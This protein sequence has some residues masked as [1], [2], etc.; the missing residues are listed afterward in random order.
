[1]LYTAAV[2]LGLLAGANALTIGAAGVR[3]TPGLK[4]KLERKP[5]EGDPFCDGIRKPVEGP[6]PD[7]GQARFVADAGYI[8]DDDEPWHST[9]RPKTAVIT[10]GML[11]S[12]F[13]SALPFIAP[14]EALMDTL[15]QVE[16]KG[17]IEAAIKKCLADGGRPGCPAIDAAEKSIKL[18]EKEGKIKKA[19]PAK[20]GAQGKG[21]DDMARSLAKTHD[22]SV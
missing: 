21:W 1:M 19:P 16:T 2:V 15:R 12:T 13:V 20:G 10:K 11:D 7:Q 17:E 18:G 22:N 9:C 6:R 8:E 14:E 3:T 5:G 4:M